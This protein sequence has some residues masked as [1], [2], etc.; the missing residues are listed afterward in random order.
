MEMAT[1]A[2]LCFLHRFAPGA[3]SRLALS[4]MNGLGGLRFL[5]RCLFLRLG[6]LLFHRH[7]DL[8][9]LLPIQQPL[10][11]HHLSDM[12]LRLDCL[13]K[14]SVCVFGTYK[15]VVHPRYDRKVHFPL[16]T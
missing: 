5:Y 8:F 10:F 3:R 11:Q 4:S 9:H 6:E 14:T 16:L 12:L 13:T 2:W 1:C 15:L 7:C